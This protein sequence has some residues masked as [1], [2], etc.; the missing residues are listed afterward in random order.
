MI[1][2][3]MVDALQVRL[4]DQE[5]VDEKLPADMAGDH[6]GWCGE[7]RHI[8]RHVGHRLAARRS[9]IGQLDA[10]VEPFPRGLRG[11]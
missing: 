8:Y 11:E 3:L 4:G 1:V 5:I 2:G 7:I 6:G 10:V 9:R